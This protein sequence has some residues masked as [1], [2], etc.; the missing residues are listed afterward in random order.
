MLF[1][2]N[3]YIRNYIVVQ[4]LRD[5]AFKMFRPSYEIFRVIPENNE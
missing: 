3:E 1:S 4:T 2:K 5:E